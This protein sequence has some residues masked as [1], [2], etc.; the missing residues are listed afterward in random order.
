[1]IDKVLVNVMICQQLLVLATL[2][3]SLMLKILQETIIII[4]PH[5][6]PFSKNMNNGFVTKIIKCM[7]RMCMENNCQDEF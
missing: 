3:G 1:M 6:Y 5:K 4:W 2:F 7:F